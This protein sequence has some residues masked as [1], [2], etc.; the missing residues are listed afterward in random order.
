MIPS[1]CATEAKAPAMKSHGNLG[2]NRSLSTSA[3]GDSA[4]NLLLDNTIGLSFFSLPGQF[5]QGSFIIGL[6]AWPNTSGPPV[7]AAMA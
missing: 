2:F 3:W 7:L 1:C 6:F 4:G 5:R